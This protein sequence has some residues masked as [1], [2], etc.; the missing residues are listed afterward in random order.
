MSRRPIEG[1]DP[2][3][4][5]HVS[6][7]PISSLK[8]SSQRPMDIKPDGIW[9]ALGGD[10]SDFAEL[11]GLTGT[12]TQYVYEIEVDYSKVLKLDSVQK[13]IDFSEKYS[14]AMHGLPLINW[15][16]VAEDWS[17]VEFSP[18]FRQIRMKLM[19]YASVDVPSG[20]VWEPSAVTKFDLITS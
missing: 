12:G 8:R 16:A 20:C 18:Y 1:L 13:V 15:Q 9:Y 5:Y 10:W 14:A 3:T 7:K 19:W 17:G 6:H 11:I 4:K 2:A